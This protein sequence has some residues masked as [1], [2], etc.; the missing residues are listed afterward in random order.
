MT[1]ETTPPAAE[2][3]TRSMGV[4]RALRNKEAGDAA[5]AAVAS[6]LSPEA[7]IRVFTTHTDAL[8]GQ[9][10]AET[11][12]LKAIVEDIDR[13]IAALN[14]ERDNAMLAYSGISAAMTA[15]DK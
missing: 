11:H 13:K 12:R 4:V 6:A 5:H 1:D 10:A 3:P 8:K 14:I 15:M 7:S 2:E 9:M